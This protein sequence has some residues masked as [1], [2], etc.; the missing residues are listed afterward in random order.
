M[1][2]KSFKYRGWLCEYNRETGYYDLYTPDELEQPKG[3]R[4]PDTECGSVKLCKEHI[5]TY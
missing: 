2:N 3:F 5:N 1:G 4:Y